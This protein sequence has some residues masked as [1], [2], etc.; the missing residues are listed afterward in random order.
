MKNLVMGAELSMFVNFVI[1]LSY[2]FLAE[3]G[4]KICHELKFL[5]LIALLCIVIFTMILKR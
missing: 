3:V 4:D 2:F 1:F 5:F